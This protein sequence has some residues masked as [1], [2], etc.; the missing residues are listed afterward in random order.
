MLPGLNL[1]G[2]SFAA[3]D[4]LRNANAA[5]S[6]SADG[7]IAECCRLSFDACDALEM[8]EVVLRHRV[9]PTIDERKRRRPGDAKQM[10]DVVVCQVTE[11]GVAVLK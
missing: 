2:R 11:V 7:Q 9:A 10:G 8:A 3:A 4:T 6:V 1:L 5:I